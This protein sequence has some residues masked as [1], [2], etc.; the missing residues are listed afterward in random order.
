MKCDGDT[1]C[2]PKTWKCDGH[3]DCNDNSDEK[4]CGM[5]SLVCVCMCVCVCVCVCV[6]LPTCLPPSVYVCLVFHVCVCV[7]FFL[8]VFPAVSL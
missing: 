4:S 6:C 1:V 8:S 2:I 7:S 5:L 3:Q